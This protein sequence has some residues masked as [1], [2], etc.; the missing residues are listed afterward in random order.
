MLESTSPSLAGGQGSD[1][2]RWCQVKSTRNT[3][4]SFSCLVSCDTQVAC[5]YVTGFRSS[6]L[7]GDSAHDIFEGLGEFQHCYF[8]SSVNCL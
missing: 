6:V 4:S 5:L 2:Q 7:S 3:W 8:V 1:F